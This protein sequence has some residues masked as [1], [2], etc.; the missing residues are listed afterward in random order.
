MR[1]ASSGILVGSTIALGFLLAGCP[2]GAGVGS[3]FGQ[4]D[5]LDSGTTTDA[6]AADA[7]ASDGGASDS[8]ASLPEE[9]GASSGALCGT[10]GL[11]QCSP[12]LCDLALGCVECAHD[13]DCPTA[14]PVCLEG[15][16]VGC[17]PRTASAN[18]KTTSD[19][20]NGT[21]C[22]VEDYECHPACSGDDAC[23]VGRTCDKATGECVLCSQDTDCQSGVCSK[24]LRRCVDCVDDSTCPRN[25]PRCRVG[26]AKCVACLSNDD[27]GVVNAICDSLTF[28]CRTGCSADAQCPGQVCDLA[29]GKCVD[30][31]TSGESH[32]E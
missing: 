21:A 26:V 28:T 27:C 23:G 30:P 1:N 2:Q 10:N 32:D 3:V 15:R 24:S 18:G 8:D 31:P 14:S 6:G 5:N 22:S 4:D 20:A 7:D 11:D 13:A 9:A 25:L 29:A 19:C 17:R 16:C 12:M